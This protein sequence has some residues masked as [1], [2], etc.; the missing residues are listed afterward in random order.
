VRQEILDTV[1]KEIRIS[2]IESIWMAE[3]FGHRH[4][5]VREA[6]KVGVERDRPIRGRA[7][8]EAQRNSRRYDA[9]AIGQEGGTSRDNRIVPALAAEKSP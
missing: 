9:R 5:D 4:D 8:S 1:A 2:A 3:Q 7:A 6:V